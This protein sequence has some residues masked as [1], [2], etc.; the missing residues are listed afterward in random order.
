MCKML[1]SVLSALLLEAV[2]LYLSMSWENMSSW[3]AKIHDKN[4]PVQLHGLAREARILQ[5]SDKARKY[6]ICIIW[7][8]Q[9][10]PD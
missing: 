9:R 5:T 3:I 2:Q 6:I 7:H 8:R 4:Q 10:T 1:C